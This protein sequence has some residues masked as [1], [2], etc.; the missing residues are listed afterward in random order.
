[1]NLKKFSDNIFITDESFNYTASAKKI[2]HR[3]LVYLWAKITFIINS[4]KNK[5]KKL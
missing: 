4:L 1:M 5:L 3:E 2:K